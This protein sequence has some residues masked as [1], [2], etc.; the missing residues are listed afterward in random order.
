LSL[1]HPEGCPP[2]TLSPQRQKQKTQEALVA[3]IVEEAER[4]AVY[5]TWED[6]HWADP[7]TLEILQL[8]L[9]QVPTARLLALLTFRPEFRPPWVMRSHMSQITLS[10]LSRT[11]V[12]EMV[13]KVTGG[14]ALSVE[15]VQQIVAKT[16]GVPLFVEELTKMVLES[17]SVGARRAVPL[18]SIP[19]PATLQDSLMAR[20][21]RLGNAKAVAQLSATLGREFSYELIQAVS[22][23]DEETLQKELT[24]L[25]EAELVYQ[26]GLP[27]QARYLFKHALIQDAAYQSLLKS[28]RQ[29]YHRQIAQVLEEKFSETKESQPELLA[30]H[31]TE[32]SLREQALPYWQRAGERATQRSAYME[33][34]A[35]LT[36]GLE[37]LKALP[38][39]PER[40]QQELM[41]QVALSTPLMLTR[42]WAAP[43]VGRV[44]SR[45]RELCR[46]IGETPQLFP[47]LHGVWTFHFIRA[48]LQTAQEL[49]E[50]LLT[51][52]QSTQ[53]SALL[54]EA[55][56]TLGESLYVR[57]ELVPAQQH[58]EQGIALYD[59]HQHRSL[60]FL[61][62]H[63]P[64]V[65]FL[66]FAA[67]ALW[68]LGYPDQALARSHYHAGL[69]A[70]RR[71]TER[72]GDCPDAAG[73][74]R[75]A[76]HRGR[77]KP[78]AFSCP[79]G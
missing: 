66:S 29:Q 15:L 61:Y 8:Y 60:A 74:S 6:L 47:V 70:S 21:D 50:Q 13:G 58:F 45:A 76:G 67:L 41:L 62:G 33:A 25:V 34:V 28:T 17:E 57:G 75:L 12:E 73:L 69:G 72:G 44:H 4:N 46:Q 31:Y 26:R 5:S 20:L 59:P 64:G 42:G 38:D 35:H 39:T 19:I 49:G 18:P 11:Q 16:D 56:R 71:G 14:K 43:E 7:S 48:E 55:H 40:A 27:P 32:A 23:L 30:H 36:R 53:D 65:S 2:L 77:V 78:D 22:P 9:D 3:W 24:Q 63:D 52:A 54:L 10:R 68:C 37:L 51:L 79:A 1:P